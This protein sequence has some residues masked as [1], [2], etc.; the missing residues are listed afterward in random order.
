MKV[1]ET[2]KLVEEGHADKIVNE[3]GQ[4]PIEC[5][6]YILAVMKGMAFTRSILKKEAN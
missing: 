3:A 6:E 2:K 5:Q 4:L 1:N